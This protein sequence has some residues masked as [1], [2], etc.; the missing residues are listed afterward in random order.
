M[1]P[2]FS[3]RIKRVQINSQPACRNGDRSTCEA[4]I[5]DHQEKGI[6]RIGGNSVVVRDI[7]SGRNPFAEMFG[8]ILGGLFVGA[9]NLNAKR[10]N[11]C[12]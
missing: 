11:G 4:K 12:H 1:S 6:V 9:A 2:T 10:R 7:M 3:G 5:D 8:E